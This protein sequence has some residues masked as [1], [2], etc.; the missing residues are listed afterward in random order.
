MKFLD[1]RG[2]VGFGKTTLLVQQ[3]QQAHGLGEKHVKNGPIV[4]ERDLRA[5]DALVHVLLHF[6]GEHVLIEVVLDLFVGYVYA[7]LF[8][9]VVGKVLEAEYV[10]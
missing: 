9:R 7:K 8:E 2:I 4:D 1:E 3:C 5:V 6:P 10:Q